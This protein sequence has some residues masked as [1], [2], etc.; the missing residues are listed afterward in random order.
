M[1]KID[2]NLGG[3]DIASAEESYRTNNEQPKDKTNKFQIVTL[4]ELN[5]RKTADWNAK[6]ITTVKKGQYLDV[7]EKVE[8]KNGS[9]SMYKLE[10]GLY[11]TTSTKYV[12]EVR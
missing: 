3:F 9:T 4:D 2:E 12:K 6:P 1:I 10:S 5:V 7:V 11:I 8:A